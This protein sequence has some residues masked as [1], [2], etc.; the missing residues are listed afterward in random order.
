VTHHFQ[1]IFLEVI[2]QAAAQALVLVTV[3]A[4]VLAACSAQHCH[5]C[6]L[7]AAAVAVV[8]E[9]LAQTDTILD[10]FKYLFKLAFSIRQPHQLA[11]SLRA[12]PRIQQ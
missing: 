9:F 10:F 4:V 2:F 3:L 12:L 6:L 1:E 11:H 5:Y 7:A 8:V